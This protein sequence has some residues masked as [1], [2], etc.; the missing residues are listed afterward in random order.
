[1]YSGSSSPLGSE[2]MP[3]RGTVADGFREVLGKF[4]RPGVERL[5]AQVEVGQCAAGAGEH[6][7][8]RREGDARQLESPR[9]PTGTCQ[10]AP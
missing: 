3:L 10:V 1:M 6:G 2:R 8:V 5:A 4:Q 7:G 9:G